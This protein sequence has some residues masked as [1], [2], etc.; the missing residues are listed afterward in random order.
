GPKSHI[1]K[2]TY[3]TGRALMNCIKLLTCEDFELFKENQNFR[4]LKH[5]SDIFINHWKETAKKL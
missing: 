1:W 2:C 5:H 3:H 4:E